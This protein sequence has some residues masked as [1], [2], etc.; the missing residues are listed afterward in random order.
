MQQ[1]PTKCPNCKTNLNYSHSFVLC[2]FQYDCTPCKILIQFFKLIKEE[3]THSKDE[4]EEIVISFRI[5]KVLKEMIFHPK[6]NKIFFSPAENVKLVSMDL[7]D[8]MNLSSRQ[9]IINHLFSILTQLIQNE[10]LL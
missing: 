5:S 8:Q 3:S 6:E 2:D 9:E 7:T 10:Q 1:I 4:F